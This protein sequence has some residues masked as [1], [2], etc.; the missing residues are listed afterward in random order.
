MRKVPAPAVEP[1]WWGSCPFV[2]VLVVLFGVAVVAPFSPSR[3]FSSSLQVGCPPLLD[4][5]TSD[6]P[7]SA[8]EGGSEPLWVKPREREIKGFDNHRHFRKF[9]E[10]QVTNNE[11]LKGNVSQAYLQFSFEGFNCTFLVRGDIFGRCDKE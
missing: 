1:C 9:G 5:S 4:E 3:V 6:T 10:F 8:G 11:P 7:L 2:A